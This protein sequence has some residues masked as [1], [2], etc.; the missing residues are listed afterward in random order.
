VSVAQ[1]LSEASS[2]Y[3]ERRREL[4]ARP[5]GSGPGERRRALA[6]LTDGWLTALL[7]AAVAPS[8]DLGGVA[9][10]AVG[11]YGRGE[12]SP[13]SDLDLVLLHAGRRDAAA[14][15]SKIWYP[16]WDSGVRLDHAMRTPEEARRLAS[17]DLTV[18]LGLLDL[19]PVAGDERLASALRTVVLADWRVCAARRLPE[20]RR[21]CEERAERAGEV[22]FDLEPDLKD[23][24][25]GLRDVVVLRAVAASW[26]TDRPHGDLDSAARRLLDVRDALHL[27]TGRAQDRLLLQEQEAVAR[28]LGLADADSVLKTVADSARTIAYAGATTWRQVEHLQRPRRRRLLRG[29]PVPARPLGAGLVDSGGEVALAAGADP[30]QD[31]TLPVRAAAT[32]AREGLPLAPSLLGRL[33]EC[34]PLPEPWPGEVRDAFVALLGAG[35]GLV[36]VWEALDRTGA[37]VR[38]LPEWALVRSRPQRNAV[39]RWTVDRHCVET[40]AE[41]AALTRRVRRP[42]LL[43]V[44]AFLHDLGKGRRRGDHSVEGAKLVGPLAD[45][46]GFS[47]PDVEVLCVLVRRHLLLVD[48]A[49]RRDLDDPGTVAAVAEA[50]GSADTLA[51]LHALTE[52]DALATGPAAWTPWRSGLVGELARRV[53]GHL[54]GEAPP[55]PLPL[56]HDQQR[57]V[58]AG[59]FELALA[60]DGSGWT[61]T[62]VA[63]DRHG[64]LAAAAGVL[65][66]HRLS[67]RS[68][69]L[70]TEDGMAVD[71]WSV[72]PEYGDEPVLTTLRTDL[73][74]ALDGTLDVVRLL[75]RREASRRTPVRPAVA[76]PQVEI[77]S[78]ASASATVLEVRAPDRPALLHKLARAL[79]LAGLDVRSARVATVGSE[80]VDAFYV[81]DEHGAALDPG[82][83]REVARIL[84]DA[85]SG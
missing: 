4:L 61:V 22:A 74:A 7:E 39:H 27:S 77:V 55:P 3:A 48:A 17:E 52:A 10:V 32:A 19:R 9:L 64:L 11:G 45:R 40:A 59:E 53:G 35:R 81:V 15:A 54:R 34:P 1:K 73:R 71:T 8:T 20:L 25:G 43:L 50:V 85:A 67:V 13:G 24:R 30:A 68:A 49:T 42:D 16:V 31:A 65:A 41:A 79:S 80:V 6:A 58:D 84:R 33:A 12:L 82:R 29:R 76:G 66:L 36:E 2:S 72:V 51:L 28:T 63:P 47:P 14:V 37:A 75:A 5:A 60:P 44:A 78:E 21:G 83:A 57:L 38:L 69:T 46:M 26:V 56:T 23:G 70:R 18:L 62:V